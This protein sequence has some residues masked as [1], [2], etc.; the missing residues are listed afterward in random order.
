MPFTIRD[1]NLVRL[2]SLGDHSEFI[3]GN[4]ES[5][6][7]RQVPGWMAK[8]APGRTTPGLLD[9]D[10][11]LNA[12]TPPPISHEGSFSS[13]EESGGW[14]RPARP[15]TPAAEGTRLPPPPRTP[16]IEGQYKPSL[17]ATGSWARKFQ[18]KLEELEAADEKRTELLQQVCD[19]KMSSGQLQAYFLLQPQQDQRDWM[20][21]MV[22][23]AVKLSALATTTM[24]LSQ[25]KT[26]ENA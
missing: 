20:A 16:S 3:I 25:C 13:V 24:Q 23:V 2:P 19:G 18:S 5:F 26:I 10:P 12:V 21:D 15:Y 6:W 11:T 14:G 7:Q 8:K 22:D 1:Q 4:G 9:G 17:L